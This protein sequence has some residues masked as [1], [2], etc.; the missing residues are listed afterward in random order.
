MLDFDT[1][2]RISELYGWPQKHV[3]PGGDPARAD[4][5]IGMW[6]GV[7]RNFAVVTERPHPLDRFRHAS[8]VVHRS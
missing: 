5:R 2:E 6:L 1:W 4:Q 3:H 8:S 7:P